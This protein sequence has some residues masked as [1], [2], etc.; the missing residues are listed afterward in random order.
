ML[1]YLRRLSQTRKHCCRIIASR[2]AYSASQ[3][4]KIHIH[5]Y[6]S[7]SKLCFRKKCC[8]FAQTGNHFWKQ[9]FSLQQKWL[10]YDEK[11]FTDRIR[12]ER[13]SECSSQDAKSS[14]KWLA[15]CWLPILRVTLTLHSSRIQATMPFHRV[16][17]FALLGKPWLHLRPAPNL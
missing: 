5:L 2:N 3:R 9:R 11:I 4:N 15:S 7:G 13:R 17:Y 8:V 10:L 14:R 6:F 1:S 16:S 12:R